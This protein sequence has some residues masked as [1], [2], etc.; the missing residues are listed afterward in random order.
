MPTSLIAR[1]AARWSRLL[2]VPEEAPPPGD[3]SD[4]YKRL[5]TSGLAHAVCGRR[6]EAIRDLTAAARLRTDEVAIYLVLGHLQR[7]KGQTERAVALHRALLM[8]AE[9]D[10]HGR[11]AALVG[12]ALDYQSSGL[13]DRALASCQEALHL[14][15]R[16]PTALDVLARLHETASDWQA[17]LQAEERLLRVQ[18]QRSR[19]AYGFLHYQIGCLMDDAGQVGRAA[20]W[21]HRALK[22][23]PGV[24]PA[25]VRLGDL[26]YRRGRLDRALQYWEGLLDAHPRYSYLVIE[27]LEAVYGTLHLPDKLT[28]ICRR[29]AEADPADWRSRLY[30]SEGA[31]R[32][33]DGE[34][35]TRWGLEALR[36]S[37]RSLAAHRAYWRSA[38]PSSGLPPRALRDFLKA[39]SGPGLGDDPHLCMMCRYRASELLWRCPQCHHWASFVEDRG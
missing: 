20:R 15:A 31:A 21:L 5:L 24:V 18:P 36:A 16:E 11:V 26:H 8:R 28:E 13:L 32:R 19:L 37:P 14:D 30:L 12:L 29:I 3:L 38:A 27:R 22:V 25:Y 39:T 4:P 6:D 35:A 1:L 7:L 33:D 2:E 9:L 10:R 17:A 34:E 23:H